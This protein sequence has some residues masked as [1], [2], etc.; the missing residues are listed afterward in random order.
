MKVAEG[1]LRKGKLRIIV[2]VALTLAAGAVGQFLLPSAISTILWTKEGL[3]SCIS[4][5]W[6]AYTRLQV[7]SEN[8]GRE[9]EIRI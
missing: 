3:R 1:N 6:T 4:S 5:A 9:Y 7:V 8:R 2:H